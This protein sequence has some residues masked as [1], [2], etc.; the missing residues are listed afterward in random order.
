[1]NEQ[2]NR[3]P[4]TCADTCNI[5][6]KHGYHKTMTVSAINHTLII[7]DVS[8]WHHAII[9]ARFFG[10]SGGGLCRLARARNASATRCECD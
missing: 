6:D 2:K 1:M 5:C 3:S 9:L 7:Y 8:R 10:R 4:V